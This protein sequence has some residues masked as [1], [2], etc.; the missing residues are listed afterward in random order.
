MRGLQRKESRMG[1][2]ESR[3]F[4]VHALRGLAQEAGYARQ[5]SEKPEYG[6]LGHGAGGL[7]EEDW[8]RRFEQTLQP[9]EREG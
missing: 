4:L 1:Q 9:A 5:Q 3:H 6:H 2:L 7:Y 8:K